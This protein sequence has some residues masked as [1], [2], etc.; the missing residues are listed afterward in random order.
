[1]KRV[2]AV[3]LLG[4][5]IG[6]LSCNVYDAVKNAAIVDLH[7]DPSKESS[8]KEETK[9]TIIVSTSSTPVVAGTTSASAQ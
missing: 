3:S 6:L 5:A 2:L 4:V 8:P 1:M 7:R 9:T